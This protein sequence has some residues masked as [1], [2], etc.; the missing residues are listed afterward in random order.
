MLVVAERHVAMCC[1]KVA[2]PYWVAERGVWKWWTAK[3]TFCFPVGLE[4]HPLL[5][6]SHWRCQAGANF[7]WVNFTRFIPCALEI[8]KCIFFSHTIS[9]V[10][11]CSFIYSSQKYLVPVYEKLQLIFVTFARI[12]RI[13]ENLNS[14]F[15]LPGNRLRLPT[16]RLRLSTRKARDKCKAFCVAA[17]A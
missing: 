2:M 6:C 10:H 11:L 12:I 9:H 8:R 15:R 14:L 17:G 16:A 1:R 7:R 3:A 13:S 4:T 5:L